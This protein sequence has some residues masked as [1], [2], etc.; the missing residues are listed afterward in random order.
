MPTAKRDGDG[1]GP[2]GRG[3]QR[4]TGGSGGTEAGGRP[5]AAL[6]PET[7]A[8][9]SKHLDPSSG[10]PHGPLLHYGLCPNSR[11]RSSA[12]CHWGAPAAPP[13]HS[14]SAN[15]PRCTANPGE[16]AAAPR[17]P[18]EQP[19]M[20][21]V[22]SPSAC[23]LTQQ[24]YDDLHTVGALG[25]AT[26]EASVWPAVQEETMRRSLKCGAHRH[27]AT[28]DDGG[29]RNRGPLLL[30]GRAVLG[31]MVGPLGNTQR[32]ATA[33]PSLTPL[34]GTAWSNRTGSHPPTARRKVAVLPTKTPWGATP[35]GAKQRPATGRPLRRRLS[36]SRILRWPSRV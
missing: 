35:G 31:T 8:E 12:N 28:L 13:R 4:Y 7:I 34:M 20:E 5:P 36:E 3:Q 18:I 24:P 25:R 14:T 1:A 10:R 32:N 2:P 29:V 16:K 15:R 30:W 17:K 22:S 9:V 23:D 6:D 11:Q 21:R 19:H 26:E 27:H 33:T